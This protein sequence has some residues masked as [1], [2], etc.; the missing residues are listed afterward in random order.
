FGPRGALDSGATT[1][2]VARVRDILSLFITFH[3]VLVS[4]V[5]F[6]ADSVGTAL[7]LIRDAFV[8][9]GMEVNVT[10]GRYGLLV[11]GSSIILLFVVEFLQRRKALGRIVRAQ[12][13]WVRWPVYAAGVLLVLLF[14]EYGATAFIYF[15]F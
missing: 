9:R 14:G 13:V 6:R 1:G 5:F 12:P 15:Q 3:L 7:Q 4:W 2:A 11:A 10:L 8:L